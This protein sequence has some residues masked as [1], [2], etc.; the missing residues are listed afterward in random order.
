MQRPSRARRSARN[1]LFHGQDCLRWFKQTLER[2]L[3]VAQSKHQ[4][5]EDAV[6]QMERDK[7]A[8]VRQMES[9]RK[10][11]DAETKRRGQ[12]EQAAKLQKRESNELKDQ[13]IK[14]ERDLK[15]AL[16]DLS[17]RD[18]EVSQLRSKQDKT[19]VEHVH[20]LEEAKRVTDRQLADAQKELLELNTYIKSLEKAKTRLIG[21]AEDLARQTER[22]RQ[23]IKTR[24]KAAKA[25]EQQVLHT[26]Q[27]LDVERK[28]REAAETATRRA[29]AEAKNLLSQVAVLQ[30]QFSTSE[31]SKGQLE[32]ELASFIVRG[33]TPTGSKR[34]VITIEGGD[35]GSRSLGDR[36]R[37]LVE[38]QQTQLRRLI[39]TQ[40][41]KGDSFRDRLLREIEESDELIQRELLP[42]GATTTGVAE[43]RNHSNISPKRSSLTNGFGNG[44]TRSRNNSLP[45]TPRNETELTNLR[46]QV[47]NMEIQMVS[48]E[49]IRQHLQ[50]ALKDLSAE[51]ERMDGSA[52]SVHKHRDRITRDNVRLRELLD[53]EAD[54]L[55]I[56]ETKSMDSVKAL[57]VKYQTTIT[58]ERANYA[59]LEDSRKALVSFRSQEPLQFTELTGHLLSS[60]NIVRTKQNSRILAVRLPNFLSQSKISSHR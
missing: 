5:F 16:D 53:E 24:E 31:R 33:D 50:S 19:I 9:L 25:Q 13:N 8:W 17:Q 34:S 39:M 44:A 42:R 55:R 40:M 35:E 45:D 4:D 43:I 59:K 46:Q 21:D 14:L 47:Q 26:R 48:S 2:Q 54:A 29:E 60:L 15:K 11:L 30:Q 6:L 18:W 57:W 56:S 27:E 36:V 51:V 12:I 22:E 52:E 32:K 3:A 58:E 37:S 1:S 41:P 28:A 7:T 38:Q 20:V 10:Q 23:E 49:R